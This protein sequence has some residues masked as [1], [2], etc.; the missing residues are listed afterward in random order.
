MS[1]Q[2]TL[3]DTKLGERTVHF[4]GANKADFCLLL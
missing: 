3:G 4:P 2:L 1:V